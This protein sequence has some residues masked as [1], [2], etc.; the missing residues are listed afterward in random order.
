MKFQLAR[1]ATLLVWLAALGGIFAQ[2]QLTYNPACTAVLSFSP[3]NWS[4]RYTT[5]N[6]DGSEV[7]QDTAA[8]RWSACKLAANWR[9]LQKYPKL[10]ARLSRLYT[11]E[12]RFFSAETDMAYLAAGGGTMYPHGLARFQTSLALHLEKLIALT[13]SSAGATQSQSI[14]A[15]SKKATAKLEARIKR[16][17]T[18]KPYTDGM[19]K[20]EISQH[21]NQWLEA[22]KAYCCGL[23]WHPS[24]SSLEWGSH[25]G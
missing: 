14:T 18:P 10:K 22:A 17:Q 24:R 21:I 13:T 5:K 2:D 3:E 20:R 25:V 6:Q 9:V 7:G 23:P 4:E 1:V 8:L 11:L 12:A 19:H 16:V 15:R